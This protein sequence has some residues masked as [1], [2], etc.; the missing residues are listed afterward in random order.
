MSLL[1]T[2]LDHPWIDVD[3]GVGHAPLAQEIQKLAASTTRIENGGVAVDQL[4]VG[5]LALCDT[6]LGPAEHLLEPHVVAFMPVTALAVA[7]H[8]AGEWVTEL[9]QRA[10]RRIG[11]RP[12]SRDHVFTRL[13]AGSQRLERLDQVV[14]PKIHLLLEVRQCIQDAIRLLSAGRRCTDAAVGASSA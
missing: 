10:G 11:H 6:L 8:D 3:T 1:A 4:E 12:A 5:P 2:V 7:E 14:G 9:L 13:E